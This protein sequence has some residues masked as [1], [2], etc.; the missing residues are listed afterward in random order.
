M[1]L[2][3]A[4]FEFSAGPL[5]WA[6]MP[7]VLNGAGVTIGAAINWLFVIL[8]SVITPPMSDNWR[9]WMFYFFAIFNALVGELTEG[10]GVHN[11]LPS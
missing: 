8:I 5:L 10:G 4:A 3:I 2:F 7:E 11:L 1:L 6:Y 9:E